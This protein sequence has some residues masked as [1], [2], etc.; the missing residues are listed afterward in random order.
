VPLL[1]ATMMLIAVQKK[2]LGRRGFSTVGGKGGQKRLIR[3]GWGR[4][5]V[6]LIVLSV[7]SLSVFLPYWILL[8]AALSKVWA[9]PLTWDNFTLHNLSFT[10]FEYG[11]TQLA[12]YNTFKL[13][14]ITATLGTLLA[15]LIDY[16][17]NRNRFRGA[18]CLSFFALRPLVVPAIVLAG[19]LF[20]ASPSP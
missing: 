1:L 8:K 15:T 18:R 6:L 11:D 4:V 2:I 12:I 16:I 5:P 13:G 20:L 14:L 7:L 17:T 9:L 10:F 19:R 3:L